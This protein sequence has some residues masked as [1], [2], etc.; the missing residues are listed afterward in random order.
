MAERLAFA[1]RAR[2]VGAAQT[3]QAAGGRLR[4][5]REVLAL[6]EQALSASGRAL[7]LAAAQHLRASDHALA[8]IDAARRLPAASV[9]KPDDLERRLAHAGALLNSY[10]YER[11]LDRGFVLVRG[12]DG[13]VT[14]ADQATPGLDVTLHFKDGKRRGAKIDGDT[15]P[16]KAPVRRKKPTPPAE[17]GQG[18]LL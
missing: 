17:S 6:K 9:R 18:S 14:E 2:L 11:V 12:P 16:K 10:S 5:P 13:P 7:N 15:P 8:R 3:V 1:T 4:H